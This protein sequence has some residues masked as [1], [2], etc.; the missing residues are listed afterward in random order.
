MELEAANG[1]PVLREQE[2]PAERYTCARNIPT[3]DLAKTCADQRER[4]EGVLC[5]FVAGSYQTFDARSPERAQ[6]SC[7]FLLTKTYM[8][9]GNPELANPFAHLGGRIAAMY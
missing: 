5:K 7:A 6:K 4:R 8:E 9:V 1:C 2:P 3:D